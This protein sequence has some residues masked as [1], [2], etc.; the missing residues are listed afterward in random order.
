[1]KVSRKLGRCSRSSISRRRL[2]NKKSRSGYKKRYAK[3]QKGGKRGRGYKRARTHKRGKRFHRGGVPDFDDDDIV[4]GS[5]SNVVETIIARD[6]P[7]GIKR[8]NFIGTFSLDFKRTDG[9]YKLNPLP[10]T[11]KPFDVFVENNKHGDTTHLVL[12]RHSDTD[13]TKYIKKIYIPVSNLHGKQE[14]PPFSNLEGYDPYSETSETSEGTYTFPDT[15]INEENFKQIKSST[16][17]LI[18]LL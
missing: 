12:L 5:L 9:R 8:T 11:N 1:M 4:P 14:G 3:T 10:P 16:K 13:N 15:P 17:I 18:L 7:E 2:R 6:L